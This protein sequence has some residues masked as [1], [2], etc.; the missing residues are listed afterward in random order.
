[1]RQTKRYATTLH[2]MRQTKRYATTTLHDMRETNKEI[3]NNTT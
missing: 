3:C 1:M 2:D